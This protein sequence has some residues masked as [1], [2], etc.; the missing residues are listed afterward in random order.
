MAS[1]RK[2][3]SILE[4]AKYLVIQS[5][6]LS[7][8]TIAFNI[9]LL[10]TSAWLIA[11]AA[12]HPE[13]STL[14]LAI[15]GVRFYGIA[16]ACAR[17]AERYVSHNMAFQGLYA[18]RIW[19]YRVIEPLAPA[20][21]R[22]YKM[23]DVLGRIMSDIEILQFFYVRVIIPPL[24]AVLITILLGAYLGQFSI[25]LTVLVSVAFLVAGVMVP[26][27]NTIKKER[28]SYVLFEQRGKIKSDLVETMQGMLDITAHNK[29]EKVF[30]DL[31]K[32]WEEEDAYRTKLR[33]VENYGS[34]LFLF[35]AQIFTLI[36]ILFMVPVTAQMNISGVFIAVAAIGV[37]SYFEALQPMEQVFFH[38]KESKQAMDRII[39]LS[40]EKPLVPFVKG[41]YAALQ[42][43]ETP[44]KFTCMGFSY[45][46]NTLYRDFSL[47]VHRGEKIAIVG[48]SGSGKTTLFSIIE[49]F[50]PYKGSI[51]LYGRELKEWNVRDSRGEISIL[52]QAPYI[53]HASLEE[54]IRMAKPTS[55]KEEFDRAIHDAALEEVV[56][57]IG[58]E[59]MV[60]STGTR[61][62]G[63]ERQRLALTRLFLNNHD[64]WLL[65]EPLEGLDQITRDKVQHNLFRRMK[66]KTVLYITHQLQGLEEMDRILFLEKG[67]IIE[68]GSYT[69]LL[70]RKG[71]FYE[72][73]QLSM[74][75]I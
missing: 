19:L 32:S 11:T 55:S 60:G 52:S 74:A 43:N 21:F 4:S 44:L 16:R 23:G 66:E 69:E 38:W 1:I 28:A 39:A 26:Y 47:T 54:N 33:E 30:R 34:S 45:G 3:F 68:E 59:A 14:G 67:K 70:A 5:Q 20:I 53:F 15:V 46:R 2:L 29:R 8:L 56:A 17:Y 51:Q 62:S 48:P 35:F 37:Q 61:L 58:L 50:Y 31:E 64:I 63:G 22:N 12:L 10:A 75:K 41:E 73:V 71:A 6:I 49:Q 24:T 9:L 27:W 65:D 57:S 13:L 7:F 40:N 42:E 25:A 36:T 18:L 72:Y